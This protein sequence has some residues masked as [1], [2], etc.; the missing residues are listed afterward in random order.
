[1]VG[2]AFTIVNTSESALFGPKSP[3]NLSSADAHIMKVLVP[4]APHET[5]VKKHPEGSIVAT[6]EGVSEF[7]VLSAVTIE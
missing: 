5:V 3:S 6:V 2:V 1:M 4:V 7:I